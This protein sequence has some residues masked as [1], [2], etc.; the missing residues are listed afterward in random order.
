MEDE[1]Q[2]ENTCCQS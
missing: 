2:Q 1:N